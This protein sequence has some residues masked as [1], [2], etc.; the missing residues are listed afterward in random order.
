MSKSYDMKYKLYHKQ[1]L[2]KMDLISKW[3][4]VM[5]FLT[6]GVLTGISIPTNIC[7]NKQALQKK[8]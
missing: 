8:S 1:Q 2:N 4:Q 7:H 6:L 5:A 3:P